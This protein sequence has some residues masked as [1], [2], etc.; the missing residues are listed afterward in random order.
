MI[1]QLAKQMRAG[2]RPR[3]FTAGEQ[4]RDFVY[5]DDAVAANLCALTSKQPGV[6]N[7][8]A[9]RSWS[10]N[11]VVEELNRVLNTDLPAEYFHNPY[12]FTQDW[13]ETDQSNAG[14]VLNYQPRFDLAAGIDAYHAS[15]KLGISLG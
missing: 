2:K 13:T 7:A 4:K 11:Q 9:G 6:F 3:I 15:G 5:V 12:T 14:A 10:F 8:G 1:H